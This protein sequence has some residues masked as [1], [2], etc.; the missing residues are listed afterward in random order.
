M[1]RPRT[2]ILFIIFAIVAVFTVSTDRRLVKIITSKLASDVP[3][4]TGAIGEE[5][6]YDVMLGKIKIG[7]SKY[8]R[9]QNAV[10]NGKTLNVM[11]FET[12]V[13]R[14]FDTEKIFT[15]PQTFLPVVIQRDILNWF[16]REK[17]TENYDQ[18][19]Y[20]VKIVKNKNDAIVFKKTAPIQNAILLPQFIRQIDELKIGMN[21]QV[22]L[23]NKSFVVK[24]SSIQDVTVPAGTFKAYY[25]ESNPKQIE[26]W[27]STDPLRIP[28]KIQSTANFGYLMV[29]KEYK[30]ALK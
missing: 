6:V 14:F 19:N 15:D 18:A 8:S 29:L 10:L 4:I 17:I 30:P 20:M 1:I 12:K 13:A 24:L 2:I 27:I 5:M 11:V 26:I 22:N 9:V 28:V 3:E 7:T 23:P 25:F 21:F 16:I